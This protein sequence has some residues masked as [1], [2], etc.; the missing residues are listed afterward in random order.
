M[1][2]ENRNFEFFLQFLKK[3]ENNFNTVSEGLANINL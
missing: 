3:T 1:N 2:K